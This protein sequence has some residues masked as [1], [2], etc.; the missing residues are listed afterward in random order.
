[1]TA[2]VAIRLVLHR[3][4]PAM[5]RNDSWDY[6]RAAVDIGRRADFYS[7]GLRDVRLPGYPAFLAVIRPLTQMR[8]DAIVFAQATCGLVAAVVGWRMGLGLGSRVAAGAMLAF[9]L[10]LNPVAP[11]HRARDHAGCHGSGALPPL[12]AGRGS[13]PI[14]RRPGGDRRHR[15]ACSSAWRS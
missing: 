13:R 10:A 12:G 5:R 1:V 6:L 11:D 15:S 7:A 14:G 8:S 3:D 9:L 2:A 4:L